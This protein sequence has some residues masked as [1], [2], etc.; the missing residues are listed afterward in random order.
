M[1]AKTKNPYLKKANEQHEYTIDHIQEL[2][3]CSEDPIYFTKNYIQI[4]HPVK[5]SIPFKLYPYQETMIR[6]FHENRQTIVLSARQTGKCLTLNT[7]V[8]VIKLSINTIKKFILWLI[9][10]EVYNEIFKKV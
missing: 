5:G 10:R 9:N 4:Q 7:N 1:A 8:R 3:R 6:T 2:K